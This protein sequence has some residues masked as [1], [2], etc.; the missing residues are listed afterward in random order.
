MLSIFLFHFLSDI[1]KKMPELEHKNIISLDDIN[2][3]NLLTLYLVLTR[4]SCFS[5]MREMTKD[6]LGEALLGFKTMIE[7]MQQYFDINIRV[8]IFF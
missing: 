7:R 2:R 8:N 5:N 6:R 3:L 1:D 4:N